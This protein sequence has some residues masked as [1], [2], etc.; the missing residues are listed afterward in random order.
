MTPSPNQEAI[1]E[2]IRTTNDSLLVEAVAGSGKT[3]T[4]VHAARL[5]P[6]GKLIRFF[7]FNKSVAEELQKKLPYTVQAGTFHSYCFQALKRKSPSIRYN[8]DKIAQHLERLVGKSGTFFEY[9]RPVK[10]L[11]SLA[12]NV[13]IPGEVFNFYDLLNSYDLWLDCDKHEA[14]FYALQVFGSTV[15]DSLTVDF[16]DM[17]YIPLYLNIPFDKCDV[18]FVDEAQ[19]LNP[20]QHEVIKRLMKPSSRLIAVGDHNQAIYAFRGADA[21]SL[22]ALEKEFNMKTLPLSVSYRCSRA[23]VAHAQQILNKKLT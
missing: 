19:D 20:V 6:P 21:D 15:E 23:V 9:L 12:K 2:A 4:C 8:A 5:I 10:Q 18:I 13:T 3:T 11:V 7:A 14:T 17:V 22:S 1:Y 16:D